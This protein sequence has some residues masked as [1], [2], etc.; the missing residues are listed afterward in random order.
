MDQDVLRKRLELELYELTERSQRAESHALHTDAAVPG[1]FAEQAT[2]R[3]NDDVL[4]EISHEAQTKA[5]QIRQAIQRIDQG[6]Y[7]E[8]FECGEAISDARLAAVPYALRCYQCESIQ[9]A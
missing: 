8:C 7:G 5:R 6:V 4:L 1:D 9:K 2:E 3:E